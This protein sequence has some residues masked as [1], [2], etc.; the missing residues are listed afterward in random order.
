MAQNH[1]GSLRIGNNRFVERSAFFDSHP[2]CQA[3]ALTFLNYNAL[4]VPMSGQVRQLCTHSRAKRMVASPEGPRLF[5]VFFE[6]FLDHFGSPFLD[7][8]LVTF[9]TLFYKYHVKYV[10]FV[11]WSFICHVVYEV[12]SCDL[13]WI[14]SDTM[15]N[16][17]VFEGSL[18]IMELT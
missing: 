14:S 16:T 3:C 2:R 9:L 15:L 10:C 13:S 7:H 11:T 6:A 1:P 12:C 17:R 5:D 18:E 4:P 8:F